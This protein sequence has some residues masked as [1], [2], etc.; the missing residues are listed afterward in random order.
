[1][2]YG[3]TGDQGFEKL[4]ETVRHRTDRFVARLLE[5]HGTACV[6]DGEEQLRVRLRAREEDGHGGLRLL[7]GEGVANEVFVQP[8]DVVEIPE[9]QQADVTVDGLCLEA[10]GPVGAIVGLDVRMDL[11]LQGPFERR[12]VAGDRVGVAGQGPP[13]NDGTLVAR[14]RLADFTR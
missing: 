4:G 10:G 5:D 14:F 6:V 2:Q 1:M 3:G 11:R 13:G 7:L 8:L 9:K 12:E